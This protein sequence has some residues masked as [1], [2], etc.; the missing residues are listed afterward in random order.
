MTG[1]GFSE[2]AFA[3]ELLFDRATETA[4]RKV[5]E[6]VRAVTGG[7]LLQDVA[8]RPHVSLAVYDVGADGPDRSSL[9]GAFGGFRLPAFDVALA[10]VGAFPGEEGVV[11]LAPVVTPEL[12]DVQ[13]AWHAAAPGSSAYYRPGSWVP[14]ATVGILLPDVVLKEAV[15]VARPA[16]PIRGRFEGVALI[17]FTDER[18]PIRYL[19]EKALG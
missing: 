8:A 5:W 2:M 3:V 4:V 13:Q 7:S 10:S 15:A 6:V 18:T 12:L 9:E 17:E 16:L 19:A 11:F 1:K 14:H